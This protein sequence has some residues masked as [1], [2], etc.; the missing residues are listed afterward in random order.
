MSDHVTKT[1]FGTLLS[2][3]IYGLVNNAVDWSSKKC[4]W[5]TKKTKIAILIALLLISAYVL[6]HHRKIKVR[7]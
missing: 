6:F 5:D 2:L 7:K 4:P 1:V 3:A